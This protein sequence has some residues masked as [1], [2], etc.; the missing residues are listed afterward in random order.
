MG[1]REMSR[2]DRLEAKCAE[3]EAE[4][5]EARRCP[6]CQNTFLQPFV[7]T[8]CGAEKLYD[9]TL[10][11]AQARAENAEQ[12]C[13]RLRGELAEANKNCILF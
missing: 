12:E 10:R 7:C 4:L 8:T 3:L 6:S 2:N 9:E 11:T 1:E 13:E 5:A